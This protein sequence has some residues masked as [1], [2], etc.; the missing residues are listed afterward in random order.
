MQHITE[1]GVLV[2]RGEAGIG[3]A[4]LFDDIIGAATAMHETRV[5]GFE[6]EMELS[7]AGLQ[8][9]LLPWE[10][11]QTSLPGPQRASDD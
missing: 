10:S 6:T 1:C 5:S 2:V 7:F 9:L 3:K 4:A 8:R 11:E